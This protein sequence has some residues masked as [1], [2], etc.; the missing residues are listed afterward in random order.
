[1]KQIEVTQVNIKSIPPN[2]L[3]Y[4]Y[5]KLQRYLGNRKASWSEEYRAELK[6]ES[7]LIQNYLESQ[8]KDHLLAEQMIFPGMEEPAKE[9]YVPIVEA[10][11][12]DH[13]RQ[14][15]RR[16]VL[17][18]EIP[19]LRERLKLSDVEIIFPS[20]TANYSDTVSRSW[21]EYK[22]V[23]KSVIQPLGH[24]EMRLEK[25]VLELGEL[26]NMMYDMERALSYLSEDELKVIEA[27]YFCKQTPYD[28]IVIDAMPFQKDKYYAIK[29]NA[30]LTI[31]RHLR[32][33]TL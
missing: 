15:L 22:G 19:R 14:T 18:K 5:R 17:E 21:S 2:I 27:K 20:M 26:E 10:K 4:R 16:E 1:M 9:Q 7:L 31:A 24:L 33:V 23:E 11:L 28:P 30:L 6:A 25:L 29:K 32:L 3:V 13:Y 12:R 8:R